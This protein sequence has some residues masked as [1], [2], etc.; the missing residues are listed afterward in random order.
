MLTAMRVV[1]K[2]EG[3]VTNLLTTV[4]ATGTADKTLV[5][6]INFHARFYHPK[7][8]LVGKAWNADASVTVG[9]CRYRIAALDSDAAEKITRVIQCSQRRVS[10]SVY[11]SVHFK[12]AER[13]G[14][15]FPLTLVKKALAVSG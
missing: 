3:W 7:Q 6:Q 11:L 13:S 5:V 1:R 10:H 15:D 12:Q 8:S 2:I 4:L 9:V 14:R